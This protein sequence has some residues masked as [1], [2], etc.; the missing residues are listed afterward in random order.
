MSMIT[1]SIT[2]HV[3]LLTTVIIVGCATRAA[4]R[5]AVGIGEQWLQRANSQIDEFEYRP[6]LQT[7]DAIG[8]PFSTP[9]WHIANRAQNLRSYIDAAGW[10]LEPRDASLT[11][12]SWTWSYR[13]TSLA[14]GEEQQALSESVN[15]GVI[16]EHK[17]LLSHS[18]G[19]SEWYL[20]DKK[21]IEQ[22]FSIDVRPLP[23]SQGKLTLT[24]LVDT[25]LQLTSRS[26]VTLA[27]AAAGKN[28][29][30]L[31]N[32]AATD[33]RGTQLPSEFRYISIGRGRSEL[34]IVVDDSRAVYPINIDP[35]VTSHSW[36]DVSYQNL[37]H[38][39]ASVSAAGDVNGDGYSDVIVGAPNYD[40]GAYDEGAAFIYY[41]SPSGLASV[42]SVF[43]ESP[44][45][46][47]EFGTSVATAGDINHDGYA[48]VI[49]GAP[50]YTNGQGFEG[51]AYVYY[52]SASGPSLSP[53]WSAESNQS[54]ARFGTTV[55]SAGDVNGDGYFDI[56]IS[57]ERYSNGENQEGAAFVYYGSPTGLPATPNWTGETNQTGAMV[58]GAATAGDV[59]GDGYSDL[60]IG[61]QHFSKFGA[62]DEGAVFLYYGSAAGLSNTPDWTA[63]SNQANAHFGASLSS[64]GDVNHDGFSDVIIGA[65]QFTD[66]ETN[67]GAAFIYFG[68]STGLSS[69]PNWRVE[70]NQ[71]NAKFGAS[72]STVRDI[73]GDGYDDVIVGAPG[74]P[75]GGDVGEAFIYH[76][77]AFGPSTKPDWSAGLTGQTQSFFG[78]SVAT[79]GD[80]DGD[81]RP[82]VIVGAPQFNTSG[83]WGGGAFAYYAN[84]F[85]TSTPTPIATATPSVMPTPLATATPRVSD[86]LKIQQE[87]KVTRGQAT[88]L[89]TAFRLAGKKKSPDRGVKGRLTCSK[90]P[91]SKKKPFKTSTTGTTTFVLSGLLKGMTCVAD[92]QIAGKVVLSNELLLR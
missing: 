66:S 58:S 83:V 41:G 42:A 81:H 4:E 72:V 3:S 60:L 11:A 32:L 79:A 45:G 25:T 35:L 90:G 5:R 77:S 36:S 29:F 54:D 10:H 33:S 50:F 70:S 84:A 62:S 14:R 24:G 18:E 61:S 17:I 63:E 39:G 78:A 20:N 52:G 48:D 28:V 27:F 9:K 56:V 73:N 23:Q 12:N 19:I 1:R 64:A 2:M 91:R 65:S 38:F 26:K 80:V 85:P 92:G 55:A 87:T 37:S 89:V 22:G 49:V 47:A 82:D 71:A 67:E 43:L 46:G 44:R 74:F 68:S 15:I 75:N 13:G 34:E 7:K 86:N 30:T 16:A 76:G 6:T 40:F 51:A 59:N 21:G 88:F 53:N 31:E 8:H 69:A 57:A